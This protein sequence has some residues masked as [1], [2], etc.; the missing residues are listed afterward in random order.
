M[1]T[2]KE[3][4][5]LTRGSGA[6]AL[7]L[8]TAGMCLGILTALRVVPFRSQPRFVSASLHR[9]L[10]L[11]AI[12]FVVLH[13][14]TT[15]GDGYAP[16]GLKDAVVPFAS[17]YRPVWLGLGA[18]AF[19]LL[20]ALAISSY[21]RRRIG[22]KTWRALHWAAYLCWPVA[23]VHALGTGSD[24]RAGWLLVLGIVAL[25][26]VVLA[27]LARIGLSAAW[28][29]GVRI[30]AVAACVAVAGGIAVWYQAGPAAR[31]WAARAGTPS[32]LIASRRPQTR[33]ILAST[34][35]PR[36]PGSF[37]TQLTGTVHQSRLSG[38]RALVVF[39]FRLLGG[40]G[41][42]LR[43]DLR[44]DSIGGGVSLTASGVSF[45]P[46]T[47]RAVYFGSV[48]GLDGSLLAADV[49]DAAGDR[50]QLTARLAIDT[51]GGRASGHLAAAGADAG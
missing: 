25:A 13:V 49:H 7:V 32:R 17:P 14:L 45:V 44:G 3:L 11:T 23:L 19:D 35:A 27:T 1:T 42:R 15:V 37:D 46:A 47:T 18:V 21:L 12:A 28:G 29:G 26:A 31:G 41:G 38:G 2:G 6:V 51:A 9:N 50:L 20:L 5:Y 4:W 34:R 36:P 10:T 8:L 40:P 22:V 48:T 39:R 30:G 16:I 43:I 33:T 24:A